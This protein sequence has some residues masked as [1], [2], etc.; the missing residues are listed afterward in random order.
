[1]KILI[2]VSLLLIANLCVAQERDELELPPT[3]PVRAEKESLV[4]AVNQEKAK[5]K[6]DL[7][8]YLNSNLKYPAA[9]RQE[10][11]E[12]RIVVEFVVEKDG[13]VSNVRAVSGLDLGAGLPEEAVRVVKNMP[14]WKPATQNGEVVRSFRNLP[15]EFK[16][17][18]QPHADSHSDSR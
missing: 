6:F 3:P 13:R 1:M 18:D 10:E 4:L 7:P 2:T 14:P 17:T 8:G 12:G 11:I 9:A 5:P 16:L 15:V